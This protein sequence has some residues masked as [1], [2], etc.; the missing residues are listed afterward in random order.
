MPIASPGSHRAF[1]G[2][3]WTLA[4]VL[5]MGLVVGWRHHFK[6]LEHRQHVM[7]LASKAELSRRTQNIAQ[8][9]TVMVASP[10]TILPDKNSLLLGNATPLRYDPG[11]TVVPEQSV[12]EAL[13]LMNAGTVLAEAEQVVRKYGETPNWQDR[14]QYVF[15]PE[16]VRKLMEDYYE[17]QRE[18]DPVMG[19]LMD[20][21]RFRIN[22]VEIVLLTYRS[23][24]SDGRLE[25]ALRRSSGER[26]VIDWESYVGYSEKSFAHL[27]ESRPTHP[28]LMRGYVQ[29]HD[30]YNY[31]FSDAQKYLSLTVTSA[32]GDEFFHAYCLRDSEMGR[33]IQE[34]LGG[35]PEDTLVNGYTLWVSFPAKAQSDRCVNLVQVP[36]GRWLILPEKK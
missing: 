17:I 21:G 11:A 33:W 27:K 25:I 15:E 9:S 3:T 10:G 34:D 2:T 14:L 20:Q 35:S 31:E 22:G 8:G 36:A 19:S 18:I 30:Y 5:T 32:N 28:T 29:L 1:M 6:V 13:P 24:R 12:I 23:A 4:I 26:L 7:E 16:R